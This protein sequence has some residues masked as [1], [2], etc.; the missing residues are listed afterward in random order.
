MLHSF[1]NSCA[2]YIDSFFEGMLQYVDKVGSIVGGICGLA[3]FF[4]IG[5]KV[6]GN[7]SRG[8]SI[9]IYPLLRPFVIGLLCANFNTVVVGGLR[10]LADPVCEYFQGLE[11]ES[12]I[13]STNSDFQKSVKK[14]KERVAQMQAEYKEEENDASLWAGI[15][16]IIKSAFRNLRNYVFIGVAWLIAF[17]ADLLAA[18]T[19]FVLIFT[20][21]FSLSILCL[22]GP[23][24][25][26]VSIFPGY[27]QGLSQW[28]ARFVCI[29]MWMPLFSLCDIFINTATGAIAHAMLANIDSAIAAATSLDGNA[30]KEALTAVNIELEKLS[31][32]VALIGAL[33]SILSAVLYKS[34][35]TL[36]SWI[37]AGGDSS[38]QLSSV[39]GFANNMAGMAGISA[40]VGANMVGKSAR[41]ISGALGG[42]IARAGSKV[43]GG[44]GGKTAD[45]TPATASLGA[46]PLDAPP[47][48]PMG[49]RGA[50]AV[51]S[52]PAWENLPLRESGAGAAAM[53]EAS[54]L[55]PSKFRQ[56]TGNTMVWVGQQ[57]RRPMLAHMISSGT[58]LQRV[59]VAKDP[60]I[61][62]GILKKALTDPNV[63]VQQAALSHEK[64]KNSPKML[65]HAMKFGYSSTATQAANML[66]ERQGGKVSTDI[67]QMFNANI[68]V[69]NKP[70]LSM[71]DG[72]HASP[73]SKFR[74]VTGN[75]MVWVGQQ[76]RRPMLAHMINSGTAQERAQAAGDP[77]IT[78]GLLRRAL[79]DPTPGVQMTALRNKKMSAKMLKYAVLFG[80]NSTSSSA[81]KLLIAQQF[82][83]YQQNKKAHA[84]Q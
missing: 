73:A 83:H 21:C 19:K 84:D 3:A 43:A 47:N 42:G 53:A 17:I 6:W 8:E 77:Y 56:V 48:T 65:G 74:Q 40:F 82:Q 64:A 72:S 32:N 16:Q 34:V 2:Q 31:S 55:P 50:A 36:A 80:S 78:E 15:G 59:E 25:F 39:A 71:P 45:K 76:M 20:R 57:M 30:G 33:L 4:Y 27:K 66:R 62:A 75:T 14:A 68:S 13:S 10:G 26:A 58:A 67:Q 49:F 41:N 9:E 23:I 52:N 46:G 37:I 12:N 79:Q 29:Y 60:Y 28:I 18:L 38:G 7:Y 63:F 51:A 24:V 54:A 1:V 22:L 11:T 44:S 81:A 35:P 5:V 70:K 69:G 61:T